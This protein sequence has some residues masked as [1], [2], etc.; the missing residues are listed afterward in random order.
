MPKGKVMREKLVAGFAC[1][2]L[3]LLMMGCPLFEGPGAAF[4][5]TPTEGNVPL[6]VLFV[7]QSTPGSTD[8]TNWQWD[9]GDGLNSTAQNPSHVYTAPGTYRVTLTVTSRLGIDTETKID[10]ITVRELPVADFSASPRTG[11][12]PLQVT[13][14]DISTAG[15]APITE[16]LWDF[17]DGSTSQDVNPVH[18]FEDPGTYTVKLTVTTAIGESTKTKAN[19]ITVQ[20]R[21][22]ASFVASPTSGASPLTV[23]FT[24]TS[25]PGSSPITRWFWDFGDGSTDT[26]QNPSHVYS[27]AGSYTVSLAVTTEVGMSPIVTLRDFI[28]VAELP[29]ANF[30]ASPTTGSAPLNVNFTDQ[31]SGGSDVITEW[32][33]DF[34]DSTSSTL[35]SPSH[36]YASDGVYD[37]TLTVTTSSGVSHSLTKSSFITAQK[38][39]NASF[40]ATPR[41]GQAPLTVQF[42]DLSDPGSAPITSWQWN[43]GDGTTSN[44]R[45]PFH[46]YTSPGRY[47]VT[48][49]VDTAVG[50]DSATQVNYIT[51]EQKPVAAFSATP[52]SGAAPL[53]VL[54][55]DQSTVGSSEITTWSWDFG[56][57]TSSTQQ[58]PSKTYTQPGTYTVKLTVTSA[59]GSSTLSK[60]NLITVRQLPASDFSSNVTTGAAPLTV[61]F[62]DESVNGSENLT[63]WS[64]DFGDG[65]TSN[66][67]NPSH[68]YSSPGIY[69]VSMTATSTVGSDTE[70]KV[71]YLT[72]RPAVNFT[73]TPTSGTGSLSV[74]FTDTTALGQ[75]D[76]DSRTWNFGDGTATSAE[77]S[78]VHI[79]SEPGVY[80]V[81]LT[82][83]T[84]LDGQ[85]DVRTRTGYITV[86]PEPAFSGD[87]LSGDGNLQVNFTNSTVLG[88]L[89]TI[90]VLWNFGDGS[91]SQTEN[92]SHTYAVPGT[93]AVSLSVTT[94][95][96]TQ[97][98]TRAGYVTVRPVPAFAANVSTGPAP[99]TVAFTNTT[100]LGNLA[101]TGRLWDFGDGSTTET[102]NPIHAYSAPGNYDVTLTLTTAQG[103]VSTMEQDFIQVRPTVSFTTDQNTGTAPLTVQ[104]TSTT[105]A[106]SLTVSGYT[107][108]FGD[109]S[110][111][112]TGAMVSHTYTATGSYD[113]SLTVTTEQGNTM[114]TTS[115]AITVT[116][117][118]L[119]DTGALAGMDRGF[120]VAPL[121]EGGFAMAGATDTG[122]PDGVDAF[123]VL[124]DG[125]GEALAGWPKTYGGPGTQQA[126]DMIRTEDGGFLLAGVRG[127]GDES[128]AYLVKLDSAGEVTWE[129]VY[130][131][132][133]RDIANA[134]IALEGGGYAFAGQSAQ[135]EHA[136]QVYVVTVDAAG[137]NA[138]EAWFGG[139]GDEAGLDLVAGPEGELIVVGAAAASGMV[140]QLGHDLTIEAS[141]TLEGNIGGI[142]GVAPAPGG[143]YAMVG[144]TLPGPDGD[145]D[146]CLL[147]LN[148]ALDSILWNRTFGGAGVDTGLDITA[149][150]AG[151][152]LITGQ[153]DQD[154]AAD[155]AIIQVDA[156]G[157]LVNDETASEDGADAGYAITETSSGG[158]GVAGAGG[159]GGPHERALLIRTEP[160][161]SEP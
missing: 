100:V 18:T 4:T 94:A 51:V 143:G 68:V 6:T 107:W 132:E 147:M 49:Q 153:I 96:G 102:A 92:P 133:G 111:A 135:A 138:S 93:Y 88:S 77:A 146:I 149:A 157:N 129:R 113:V 78:P 3:S 17:G 66:L 156:D 79:Y 139:E 150:V 128:D 46:A 115:G 39:P 103:V 34:G 37:V 8:L 161:P 101:I 26:R 158:V 75:L 10:F 9:F 154:G 81:S 86:R 36:R 50:G 60:A 40:S 112:G 43:F 25:T 59:A 148:G 89:E 120:A 22:V 58:N 56:D 122:E 117:K 82:L 126:L 74:S 70:T 136:S 97:T 20:Q 109:G 47:T 64:W 11:E 42:T 69:T 137:K 29:R 118:I 44:D 125:N 2:T 16:Y 119:G 95:A 124:T 14:N 19:F 84:T 28:V 141:L 57:G 144:S 61:L 65:T 48:L 159:I 123:L 98:T 106:G 30:S 104:F 83:R 80:N 160:A 53:T 145:A 151:G 76:V 21:P 72:V 52:T 54:F 24:D 140:L 35:P 38:A 90:G 105:N 121:P 41:N 127:E 7:D 99:L 131:G 63:G 12:G 45:N 108:D 62:S 73:G 116:A 87:V 55:A 114:R 1:V 85:S 5:A 71:N 155:V 152:Y 33:W 134:V 31:S 67:Q 32:L 13:F 110:N 130:G 142:H 15:A 27:A 23:Q 91:T